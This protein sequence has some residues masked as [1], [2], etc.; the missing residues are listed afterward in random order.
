MKVF[1]VSKESK[2]SKGAEIYDAFRKMIDSL[3]IEITDNIS[4]CDFVITIGGDGT[5]LKVGKEAAKQGL[6]LLGINTGRLGFMATV[7]KDEL[8]K[9][10]DWLKAGVYTHISHRMMFDVEVA[11]QVTTVLNDVVISRKPNARLPHFTVLKDD[12]EV[13]RVRGDGI[14]IATPT[15]S[16]AYSLSAGGPIIEP[17]MH[18]FLVTALCPHTLFNRPMIFS[19]GTTLKIFAEDALVSV[20]GGE[21]IELKDGDCIT[22]TK[23][24]SSLSLLSIDG[25]SFYNSL[26]NKLMK[27]LK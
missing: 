20:D 24:C 13:M 11:E 19:P 27:P 21:A 17:E 14:I 10:S 2:E 23:S 22:V 12:I 25:D 6:P 4:E 1:V 8:G 3:S 16:T 5:I 7:E 9:L 15:G 26:H 18:C